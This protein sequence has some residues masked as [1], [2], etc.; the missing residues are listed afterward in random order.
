MTALVAWLDKNFV[1]VAMDTLQV[2]IE[3][4][5]KSVSSFACKI[6]PLPHLKGVMCGVGYSLIIQDWLATIHSQIIAQ[7][8]CVLDLFASEL[9]PAIAAK[10]DTAGQKTT[11]YHFGYD[12]EQGGYRGYC[13][14]SED[15][16]KSVEKPPD[17]YICPGGET[18]LLEPIFD[19][20]LQEFFDGKCGEGAEAHARLFG[21]IITALRYIQDKRPMNER[22]NI[23]G[24]VHYLSLT[25]Q[26]Y[27]MWVCHTFDDFQDMYV[28]ML[29]YGD[30]QKSLQQADAT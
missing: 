2:S 29:A 22:C 13:Y 4:G 20:L 23:G 8:V 24:E 26:G 5:N 30:S 3:N 1:S 9:L 16:Y 7:N 28:E 17:I 21:S 6:F 27:S 14:R 12:E 11:I 25:A 19:E 15:G 10:Y 18:A